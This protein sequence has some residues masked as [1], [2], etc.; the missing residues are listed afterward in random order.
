MTESIYSIL[1]HDSRL[2]LRPEYFG[3]QTINR[4]GTY[5]RKKLVL[6]FH[7]AHKPYRGFLPP[8]V[9]CV[10]ESWQRYVLYANMIYHVFIYMF[11]LLFTVTYHIRYRIRLLGQ[12]KNDKITLVLTHGSLYLLMMYLLLVMFCLVC[13]GFVFVF[14]Y[15]DNEMIWCTCAYD[16]ND[17]QRRIISIRNILSYP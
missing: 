13:V 4:H 14:R 8:F 11:F 6:D 10:V 16:T 9:I 15:Y 1:S 5:L 7:G 12:P 2:I 3:R 17:K